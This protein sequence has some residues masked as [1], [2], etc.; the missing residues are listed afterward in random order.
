MVS[1]QNGVCGGLDPARPHQC[2][3][4][5]DG[6]C[7]WCCRC[8]C[9][10][11]RVFLDYAGFG[12][13][14]ERRRPRVWCYLVAA[15]GSGTGMRV[16]AAQPTR[17]GVPIAHSGLK[18]AH[19]SMQTDKS[20]PALAFPCCFPLCSIPRFGWGYFHP[21]SGKHGD[22]T[23]KPHPGGL[24]GCKGGVP[25][26]VPLHST[27]SRWHQGHQPPCKEPCSGSR[28]CKHWGPPP[29]HPTL[30]GERKGGKQGGL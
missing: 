30:C 21:Y 17:S 23:P 15:G 2:H 27:K 29:R 18:P 3:T 14:W 25:I 22:D 26:Q 13:Y 5:R 24:L 1:P 8:N 10:G 11:S 16:S 19:P 6:V 4:D 28:S 7:V 20:P 12:L 9:G